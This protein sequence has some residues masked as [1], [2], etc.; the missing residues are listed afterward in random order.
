MKK[1]T[2]AIGVVAVLGIAYV[3]TAWYTGN[4]IE[5]NIDNELREINKKVNNSQDEYNVAITH[6]NLE[7]NIFSTKLHLTVTLS[8]RDTY[9]TDAQ[10]NKLFDDDIIIHHGPFPMAAIAKGTFSPQMAWIEYQMTEAADP[11]LWKLLGN[12]PFISGHASISY[13]NYLRVKVTNKALSATPADLKYLNGVLAI[14]EGNYTFESDQDFVNLLVNARLDKLNYT[15]NSNNSLTVNNLNI[16]VKPRV[17]SNIVDF[18]VKVGN[19][20]IQDNDRV[21]SHSRLATTVDNF[22]L[23]GSINYQNSDLNVQNS[24]DKLSFIPI[25]DEPMQVVEINKLTLN[26][27][28]ALNAADTVDGL[29]Q[30]GVDS[31]IYGKQNLGSG[32]FDFDFQGLDKKL[33]AYDGLDD[34]YD[35]MEDKIDHSDISNIKLSLNKFNWH[36]VAGDINI[37][38]NAK[39]V[40]T[41]KVQDAYDFDKIDSFNLKIDAP[42]DVLAYMA[43]QIEASEN[44]EDAISQ[45]DINKAKQ[46]LGMMTQMFL[47][48]VKFLTFKKGDMLGV[49][50]EVEYS[51]ENNIIKVNGKDIPKEEFLEDF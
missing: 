31:V 6:S 48:N 9:E 36:N 3:G 45:T 21:F 43:A 25:D 11:D 29:L 20:N 19:L 32:I 51:R 46:S 49:F 50:S 8:P 28:N 40:D 10:P 17:E 41:N 13:Q 44:H 42:F 34:L 18:D 5:N 4:I 30:L 24:I 12:Q 26:Q 15:E 37:S 35:D 7:K 2:L 23:T 39:V 27:K 16:A 22:K 47:H 1:T 38:A 33:F 14:S